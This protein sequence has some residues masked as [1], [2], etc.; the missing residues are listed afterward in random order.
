MPFKKANVKTFGFFLVFSAV[1]WLM[2]QFSKEYTQV[3]RIPIKY[4]NVPLDKSISDERPEYLNLRLQEKGFVIIWNYRI[5]KPEL[6]IN[7]S[8]AK[9]EN[10][11]LVYVI[12]DHR[13]TIAEQ[14]GINFE[15]SHF[16]K[17]E[18]AIDFQLK[19]EKKIKVIPRFQLSY[20][21]GYSA[22]EDISLK[23]D[24]IKVSGPEKIID[25]LQSVN[26]KELKIEGIHSN[27]SGEVELDTSNMGMLTFY[28]DK[29]NYSQKVEKFTEGKVKID[30]EVLNVPENINLVIFPKEVMVYYQVNLKEYELV[31]PTDFRVVCDYNSLEPGDNFL[32]AEIVEKPE[33]VTNLRLN[34]RKIEFVIKR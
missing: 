17:D 8:T 26:T 25:T 32:I 16:L 23:P 2:V 4:V 9:E 14:L 29:V 18:I 30:V 19:K 27:I 5:F 11:Q 24:S 34:E 10:G 28:Q 13:D 3:I 22:G 31:E 1:I 33:F 21:V 7:L 6:T 15:K 12:N 20:G